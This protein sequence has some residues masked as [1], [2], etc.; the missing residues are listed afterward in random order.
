MK[1]VSR[2]CLDQR[3]GRLNTE[4]VSL[5]RRMSPLSLMFQAVEVTEAAV[6]AATEL[7]YRLMQKAPTEK[8]RA[9]EP[10]SPQHCTRA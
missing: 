5:L 9:S 3:R 8:P 7:P 6:F 10:G 1:E 4:E 2:P